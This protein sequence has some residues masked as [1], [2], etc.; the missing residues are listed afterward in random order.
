[1]NTHIEYQIINKNS[2]PEYAVIPYGAFLYLMSQ[3]KQID[4]IPHEV[5]G[6]VIKKDISMLQ[7]W[8]EHLGLT[9]QV[10]A[11]RMGITQAAYSQMESKNAKLRKATLK[12][13]ADAMELLP[14]QLL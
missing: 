8:R 10:L 2:E 9:Q 11:D 5:V 13:L 1:M 4:T 3:L 12:K 14:E 6:L 7:A